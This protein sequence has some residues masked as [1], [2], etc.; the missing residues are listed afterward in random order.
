MAIVLQL[1]LAFL[2]KILEWILGLLRSGQ[3]ASGRHLEQLNQVTWYAS[4]IAERAPG[5][6]ATMGGTPP[7]M[8]AA[9]DAALPDLGRY[10]DIIDKVL[11]LFEAYA[12][13]TGETWDDSIAALVRLVLDRLLPAAEGGEPSFGE[14]VEAVGDLPDWLMPL[15]LQ[16]IR[17]L[18]TRK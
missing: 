17:L 2:P 1:L 5:V 12:R 6:G 4:Q 18:L 16:V 7:P 13:L 15:I 9:A 14:A 10:R 11:G 8:R 3:Y